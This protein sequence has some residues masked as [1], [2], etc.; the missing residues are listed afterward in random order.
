M[1]S[2]RRLSVTCR[3]W[4]L[5]LLLIPFLGTSLVSCV[6]PCEA[7]VAPTIIPMLWVAG[8]QMYL[9]SYGARTLYALRAS[10]GKQ[11]WAA[12]GSW[13]ATEADHIY[14]RVEQ[15][16]SGNQHTS[17]FLE[18]RQASTGKLLWHTRQ[19]ALFQI[20]GTS[21]QS[22]FLY[23][24]FYSANSMNGTPELTALD[25]STGSPRWKVPLT[26][27]ALT[28][29][30]SNDRLSAQVEAGIVYLNTVAGG[31]SAYDE[32]SGALLWN[33]AFA[34]GFNPTMPWFVSHGTIYLSSDHLYA[35]RASD[36]A[37]IWQTDPAI[38]AL[39]PD[40]NI[41]YTLDNPH[42]SALRAQ[43]GQVLWTR[44]VTNTS[45]YYQIIKLI[46]GVLYTGTASPFHTPPEVTGSDFYNGVFAN[47]TSDGESLWYHQGSFVA[48]AGAAGT[49]Y[50]LSYEYNPRRPATLTALR[51]SDGAPLWHQNLAS[52]AG[53][54]YAD[55]A[56]YTGYAGDNL[57]SG[58]IATGF[59]TAARLRPTDGKQLWRFQAG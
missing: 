2:I 10:D 44:V 33:R 14:M 35:L 1:R 3:A 54:V 56:L 38:I 58:C 59:A 11:L 6:P 15:N 22:V 27:P 32:E 9:Y 48:V 45:S 7:V 30:Y 26:A 29:V 21:A 50:L 20:A 16:D 5:P 41:I 13:E 17:T 46:D 8:G 12:S 31:I 51:S 47:R 24:T 4:L 18:A 25:A 43:D 39:D 34:S 28:G 37:I 36:G 40:Q 19:D 55:G 53:L 42:L 52:A 57:T 23:G 49:T